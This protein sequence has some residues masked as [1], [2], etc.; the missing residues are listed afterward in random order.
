MTPLRRI[1][2][3]KRLFLLPLAVALAVNA[4][5]YALA[6]YPLTVRVASA[7]RRAVVAAEVLAAAKA[8]HAQAV[9]TRDGKARA[10]SDLRTFYREVLPDDLAG[11]RRITYARLAALAE[12]ANLRYERRSSVNEQDRESSLARLR[13]TM[14]L[15]GEYADVRQFIYALETS[16]EFVVIEDVSLV[17]RD[18]DLSA[19]ILTLEVSTYYWAGPT[20]A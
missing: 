6:V 8:A 5:L 15:A 7:E 12:A 14:V 1:V 16:V 18:Q 3:E 11:A 10:D 4:A 20:D 2:Q 19:L 13:T 9:A 17:Q